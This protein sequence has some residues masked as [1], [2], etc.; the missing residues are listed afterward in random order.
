MLRIAGSLLPKYGADFIV[1]GEV[2]G[3]RPMS[4]N[5]KALKVVQKLSN[6]GDKIVRPLSGKLLEDV[7]AFARFFAKEQ[8]LDIS[9]RSTTKQESLIAKYKI[10]QVPSHGGG[11]LLTDPGFA[12]KMKALSQ[13][14][15][16]T[17]ST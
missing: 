14:G 1:T 10:Q 16:C 7:P 9:G 17:L 8:L 12:A 6:C 3:Q 4:Q 15:V 13:D 5:A 11:C 2:L